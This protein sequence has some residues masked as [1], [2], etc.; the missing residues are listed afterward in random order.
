[1]GECN[2]VSSLN[3]SPFRSRVYY[4]RFPDVISFALCLVQVPADVQ[5]WLY[6]LVK[7]RVAFVS[8]MRPYEVK[9]C[10]VR[11][12]VRYEH[13]FFL[14]FFQLPQ[15]CRIFPVKQL[16]ILAYKVESFAAMAYKCV[17]WKP[18]VAVYFPVQL[19]HI[20]QPPAYLCNQHRLFMVA[21]D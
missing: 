5:C 21:I 15:P 19:P 8:M 9:L 11:W 13:Y 10:F 3:H 14:F 1:M 6:F 20:F 7:L 4:P 17:A 2:L 16:K 12:L 18:F